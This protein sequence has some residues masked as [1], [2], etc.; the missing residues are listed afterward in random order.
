MCFLKLWERLLQHAGVFR[1]L[2][3][4]WEWL[5]PHAGV[6]DV[7]LCVLLDVWERLCR[8][9]VCFY[10]LRLRVQPFRAPCHVLRAQFVSFGRMHHSCAACNVY[11]CTSHHAKHIA[12]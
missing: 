1:F 6:F 7:C 10:V 4:L 3:E 8:M 2:V 12:S 11:A 9:Q 5:L